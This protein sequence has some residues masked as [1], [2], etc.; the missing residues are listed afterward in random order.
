M[1]T[2]EKIRNWHIIQTLLQLLLVTF[3]L[4]YSLFIH[5]GGTT[6]FKAFV[7]LILISLQFSVLNKNIIVS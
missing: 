3:S 7:L 5:T 4:I 1:V 6:T 2:A